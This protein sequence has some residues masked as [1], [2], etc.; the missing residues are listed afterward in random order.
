M[1]QPL[2]SVRTE[3]SQTHIFK[4]AAVDEF[5]SE[6]TFTSEQALKID[7]PA[8]RTQE[9]PRPCSCQAPRVFLVNHGG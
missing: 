1:D 3:F 4:L 5:V 6:P 7:E 2:A 8:G 9:V